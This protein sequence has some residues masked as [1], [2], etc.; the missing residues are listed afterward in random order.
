M[1]E[2][3]QISFTGQGR[4]CATIRSQDERN[5]SP[6]DLTIYSA[7]FFSPVAGTIFFRQFSNNSVTI[8]GKLFYVTNSPTTMNHTWHV[9]ELGVSGS[10]RL[11]TY[12]YLLHIFYD[13]TCYQ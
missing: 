12:L 11:A 10:K 6:N 2:S 5:G 3:I 4:I 9:H 7:T 1:H 8:Y 13:E